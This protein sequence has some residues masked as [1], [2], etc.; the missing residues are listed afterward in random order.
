MCSSEEDYYGCSNVFSQTFTSE[1]HDEFSLLMLRLAGIACD[2]GY[3]AY[4]FQNTILSVFDHLKCP[5]PSL[6]W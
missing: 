5:I 4:S 3:K 2:N 6:K 1:T